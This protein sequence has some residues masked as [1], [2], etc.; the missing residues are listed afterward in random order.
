MNGKEIKLTGNQVK[1]IREKLGESQKAFS[2]RIAVTQPV[3]HRL[4]KKGDEELTGP[5][6]I[7]ISQIAENNN[8]SLPS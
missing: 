6:I 5:E 2:D 3:I 1:H 4:E 8:I 7:L